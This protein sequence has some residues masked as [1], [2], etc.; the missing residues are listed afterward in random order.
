MQSGVD[1]VALLRASTPTNGS[2]HSS[3]WITAKNLRDVEKQGRQRGLCRRAGA[4]V[5]AKARSG[6]AAGR[7]LDGPTKSTAGTLIL[8]DLTG[9]VNDFDYKCASVMERGHFGE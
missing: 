6:A 8:R 5:G 9:H 4:E 7:H 3:E 1:C 2:D